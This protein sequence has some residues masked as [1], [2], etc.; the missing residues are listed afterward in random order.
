[1]ETKAPET[2]G[3]VTVVTDVLTL[4]IDPVGATVVSARLND[5]PVALENPQDTVRLFTPS[6][7]DYY[8]AQSGLLSRQ[9]AP[10]HTSEYQAA[11][12][13]YRLAEGADT[14]EVPFTWSGAD[15]VRVTKTF[16][17]QRGSYVIQV[18]TELANQ[19][20]NA[21][22]GALYAQLQRSV[23]EEPK[24]NRYNNPSRYSFN[25]IGFYSPEE[26]LEKIK[27]KKAAEEPYQR[28]DSGGWLAMIQHYFFAAWIPPADES[29]TYSTQVYTPDGQP[30]YIARGV[31][32]QVRVESGANHEFDMRLYVGPKLQDTLDGIAPGL[33]LTVNYGIFTVISA[34]LFWLLEHIHGLVGNWGWA[35]VLLTVLVKLAFFKLTE[36]QY[37]SMAR[38]RKL[39]PRIEKLRER[40]GD[41]RQRMSQAMMEMYREERVNPLGGCLPI[42]VQI[43]SRWSCA[44]R[45]SSCGSTTCP[46][47]IR[48]SSC[49]R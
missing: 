31:A 8:I 24:G 22:T 20:G 48:I 7:P 46:C 30:R 12:P 17:L 19:G 47:A 36:A 37:R 40:Y 49:R 43:R 26:K 38:M 25:G 35:I 16:V 10:N 13:E 18:R 39:Q 15:G 2:N 34:P 41:D 44:R 6:G 27:F 5:Y 14:L 23:P 11:M 9:P 42:V 45:R 3:T 1:V 4:E 21:W 28:T 33:D 32:P 29:V